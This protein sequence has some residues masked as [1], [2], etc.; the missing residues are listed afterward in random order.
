MFQDLRYGVRMLLKYKSFTVIAVISLALGIGANTLIFSIFHRVVLAPLPFDHPERLV[1]VWPKNHRGF[2]VFVS[3]P[4]FQEWKRRSRSFDR[5]SGIRWHDRDLTSPGMAEHVEGREVSSDFFPTLGVKLALGREFSAQEDQYGGAPVV[6]ISNKFWKNRFGG[7]PDAIGKLIKMGGVDYTVVGILPPGF[8]FWYDADVYTPLGQLD[9]IIMNDRSLHGGIL[10][11]GRLRPEV[12]ADQAQADMRVI[13]KGLDQLYPDADSGL[14]VDVVSLKQEI[15]GDTSGTLLLLLG[16][17]G[18]VLLI[19]CAN[20]AN[21]LL[22]RSA[23]RNGEF[24]VRL[25]LGASRARVVRQLIIESLSLSFAGGVLGLAIA[26]WGTRPM[27]AAL[28]IGMP[29]IE[30]VSV[31]FPALLFTFG[32]ALFVGVLFGILPALRGSGTDLQSVIRQG[33]RGNPR[34]RNRAQSVLVIA[35][36]A[37]TLVL[38]TGA[39]LLFRTVHKYGA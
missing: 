10:C 18:L 33:G 23:A 37:L 31:N 32:L 38:L 35:Q 15:V 2:H 7:S 21:L 14:S 24:A 3:Y 36:M 29:G 1:M 30:D 28:P 11:I 12:T 5:I 13:Q 22:A 16:A 4:D 39:S 26:R 6:V 20:V 34:G 9:P 19:A 25:A 27:L 17:V 8:S